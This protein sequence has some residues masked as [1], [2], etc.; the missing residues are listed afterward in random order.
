[1]PGEATPGGLGKP[2]GG[3]GRCVLGDIMPG[4]SGIG[5]FEGGPPRLLGPFDAGAVRANCALSD[6]LAGGCEPPV[7]LFMLPKPPGAVIGG[8]GG[9]GGARIGMLPEG[10]C[11]GTGAPDGIRTDG[12]GELALAPPA[13]TAGMRIEG[14]TGGGDALTRFTLG[15]LWL[16]AGRPGLGIVLVLG[17]RCDGRSCSPGRV[18]GSSLFLSKRCVASSSSSQSISRPPPLPPGAAP[19]ASGPPLALLSCAD[20]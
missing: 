2:G 10:R 19:A 3:K 8:A 15:G 4:G 14:G 12:G 1:M 20:A 7:R 18:V 16:G 6:A 17:N 13:G 11:E 5:L 9:G